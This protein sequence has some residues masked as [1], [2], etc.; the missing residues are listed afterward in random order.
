MKMS[1]VFELPLTADDRHTLSDANGK[2]LDPRH[3]G[4]I[5]AAYLINNHDKLVE[6]VKSLLDVMHSAD[7][8]DYAKAVRSARELIDGLE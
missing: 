8:L 3:V 2:V 4:T 7:A 5:R 6:T 1:D